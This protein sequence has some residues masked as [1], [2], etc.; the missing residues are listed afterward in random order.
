MGT[1]EKILELE[2]G[3]FVMLHHGLHTELLKESNK[4]TGFKLEQR[5]EL[6]RYNF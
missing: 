2:Q 4:E 1:R 6:Q 5:R 3:P